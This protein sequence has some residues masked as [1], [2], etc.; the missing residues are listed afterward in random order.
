MQVFDAP[1]P[2][3]EPLDAE[4]SPWLIDR[5]VS[6]PLE[7]WTL[8]LQFAEGIDKPLA[9]RLGRLSGN[10]LVTEVPFDREELEAVRAFLARVLDELQRTPD[11]LPEPTDEYP[12]AFPNAEIARMGRAVLAV[13]DESLRRGEPFRAW[14]E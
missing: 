14:D 4:R 5:F 7:Y 3:D 10:A 9:E 11:L 6:F 2:E 1:G 13:F 12:D 8:L